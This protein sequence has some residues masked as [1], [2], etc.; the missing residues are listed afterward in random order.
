MK[1]LIVCSGLDVPG[2]YER[3]TCSLANA[4]SDSGHR[5]SLLISASS[6][7]SFYPVNKDIRRFF[8]S[9]KFRHWEKRQYAY[10]QACF[11]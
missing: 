3:M 2:G 9:L 1:I 7:D 8:Y 11:Y 4:L 10:A 6:A 5:V